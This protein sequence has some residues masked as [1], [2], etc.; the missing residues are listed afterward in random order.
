MIF[1][2]HYFSHYFSILG[3][4]LDNGLYDLRMGPFSDRNI[5]EHF[6]DIVQPEKRG[7]Q[8]WY[9]WIRPDFLHNHRCFFGSLKGHYYASKN[10]WQRLGAKKGGVFFESSPL[11]VSKN[12]G[13]CVGRQGRSIDTTLDPPPFLAGQ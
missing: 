1:T 7:G 12:F 5:I 8:E 13:H 3:H 11:I 4:P 9:Q 10:Q 2:S 6:K